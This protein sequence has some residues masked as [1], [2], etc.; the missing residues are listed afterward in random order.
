[1]E[2]TVFL[3]YNDPVMKK[4]IFSLIYLAVGICFFAIAL[5]LIT[6]SG[7]LEEIFAAEVEENTLGVCTEW[8]S[9]ALPSGNVPL[10]SIGFNE[11]GYIRIISSGTY[12]LEIVPNP[13]GANENIFWSSS[14]PHI[15]NVD[16]DGMI[17]A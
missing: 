11:T 3:L 6:K 15:A 10:E 1:M 4:Y 17:S 7:T 5:I 16:K 12:K 2:Y 8:E 9:P 14:Q 13:E